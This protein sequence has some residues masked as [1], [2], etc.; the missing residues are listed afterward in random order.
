MP[1]LQLY[2]VQPLARAFDPLMRYIVEFTNRAALCVT[3]FLASASVLGP[4][5]QTAL[6]VQPV[7]AQYL[8]GLGI[9][10]I[11]GPVVETN[12][13]GYASLAQTDTGLHLRQ[14]S[15][16]WIVAD[17]ANPSNRFVFINADIAMG[18][19]GIRRSVVSQLSSLYPGVYSNTNVALVS[20]HQHSGVGGYLENLLPQITSLGYVKETADA[21]V[22]GTVLAVQRAHASLAPG[23]LSIGNTSVVDGNINRSPSAYLANPAAERAL[24]QYDQDKELSLLRFDDAQ[25]NARGFLSFFPVHGTSLYENNTLV[26]SDNKGMAA[27]LYE[28]MVEPSSMPGN[29]TFVAGFTQS[30]V[31]DTSPNTLGAFCESPGKSYDG[32]PCDF[33]SSTCGGTV[34]DC[35][36]RGP[37]FRTSDFESNRI[38]AQLQV[39]GA[40]TLMNS[41]LAPVSGTVRSVHTYLN[42]TWHSFTLPNGT[43]VQTCP[44]AMGYSFAGGTTDGPGAFDFVQGDNSSKPQNPF[45]EIVKG[46]VTPYPPAEQ[47]ACQYP[48]PILLD[49][50]YANTPYTWSPHTV[51]IQMLRVGNVVMLVMPGELTTM[52]G[53]RMR[54]A[55]R[56]QLIAKGVIGQNAYVVIAGPANTYAHYV[57]TKEEYSVQR[58]EGASTIF[59][60]WTLDAYIDKYGSLVSY[61]A[62]NTSGSPPS[63]PAP[64]DLTGSAISLRTGVVFDSAPIGKSFG[65]VISDVSSSAYHVGDTVAIQFVG[66]NPR[67]NL[68]LEETFLSVDR[69]VGGT[70]QR[71]RSDSHPSTL[72]HWTRTNTVLG[73]SSVNI[74]WTIESATPSGTYRIQY[75]GDSKPLIGSISP[76][77]GTSSNFTIA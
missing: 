48:K 37:G 52:S 68:R 3:A 10:D 27:H 44:P 60:Q 21:I 77:T 13:M 4:G 57:A 28:A 40:K 70:W 16:A 11:T 42:M 45:W 39:D 20:T 30:N 36:G 17:A 43:T 51:D 38:I 59:G 47:V 24:Y 54:N 35:H 14:R 46:V 29:N 53:R 69:L 73:T 67:N 72:Y 63:D 15:R 71:Y 66:A 1:V 25:G 64:P 26:S 76:F 75:F 5:A 41:Q 32:M 7:A 8:L 22:A 55:I 12:M 56:A 34:E 50:G 65:D 18:D 19:T 61:L 9:G 33:N 74:T 49:T 62:D 31:G 2:A 6:G 58:Y 23:K